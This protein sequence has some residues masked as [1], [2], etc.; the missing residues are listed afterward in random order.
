MSLHTPNGNREAGSYTK[1]FQNSFYQIVHQ[2]QRTFDS[3]KDNFVGTENDINSK[4]AFLPH[5]PLIFFELVASTAANSAVTITRKLG[6]RV[7]SFVVEELNVIL[8]NQVFG[9]HPAPPPDRI[10]EGA[11]ITITRALGQIVIESA[12]ASPTTYF[13]PV[14]NGDPV[15]PEILFDGDG[16]VIMM[17]VPI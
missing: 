8:A 13:E 16:D 4:R 9:R 1:A 10:V 5:D 14:T 11:N 17:E 3:L 12:S 2:L 7:I 15:S 6:Q